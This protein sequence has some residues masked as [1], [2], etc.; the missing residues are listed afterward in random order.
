MGVGGWNTTTDLRTRVTGTQAS[1][2]AR[3]ATSIRTDPSMRASGRTT[4]RTALAS[5]PSQI[6]QFIPESGRTT[7]YT[8]TAS[9]K[10]K[11]KR[12]K[13]IGSTVSA[14]DMVH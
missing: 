7:K 14:T 5:A 6:T 4:A 9:W 11:T 2:R 1:S 12:M 3:G 10:S 13:A 8:A